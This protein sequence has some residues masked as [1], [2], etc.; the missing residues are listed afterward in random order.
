MSRSTRSQTSPV[1]TP[2]IPSHLSSAWS[3]AMS[4]SPNDNKASV[5]SYYI[6]GAFAPQGLLNHSGIAI[7]PME[8]RPITA[9]RSRL[10][11][12]VACP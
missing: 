6:N 10:A 4:V 1:S 7:F 12:K 11:G 5:V 8:F 2:S 9:A 3:L